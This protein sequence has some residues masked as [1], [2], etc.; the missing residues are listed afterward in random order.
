[1]EVSYGREI[2]IRLSAVSFFVEMGKIKEEGRINSRTLFADR[3]T[4]ELSPRE[5]SINSP[6]ID[7]ISSNTKRNYFQYWT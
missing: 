3:K 2:S 7:E 6:F 5:T 4:G 1:M